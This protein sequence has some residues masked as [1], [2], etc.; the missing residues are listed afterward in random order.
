[1]KEKDKAYE[2]DN[3][4][5]NK[6]NYNYERKLKLR[7]KW[8]YIYYIFYVLFGLYLRNKEFTF[9]IE[10]GDLGKLV[11]AMFISLSIVA[12]KWMIYLGIGGL[13]LTTRKEKLKDIISLYFVFSLIVLSISLI[14]LFI[15]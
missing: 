12:I 13:I 14:P 4:D 8:D 15:I 10:V 6:D 1:M 9:N 2:M 3:I 7:L 5:I 11:P